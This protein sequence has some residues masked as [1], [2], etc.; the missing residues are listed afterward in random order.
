MGNQTAVCVSLFGMKKVYSS[1][2][3]CLRDYCLVGKPDYLGKEMDQVNF[4]RIEVVEEMGDGIALRLTK[5]HRNG[6]ESTMNFSYYGKYSILYSI[7]TTGELTPEGIERQ[8]QLYRSTRR[9]KTA[10]SE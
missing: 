10:D 5:D 8:N 6:L 7:E 3:Y 9:T 2:E 1:E 4:D